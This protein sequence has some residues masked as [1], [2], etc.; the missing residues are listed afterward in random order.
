METLSFRVTGKTRDELLRK[1]KLRAALYFEDDF[2]LTKM[3]TKLLG[4]SY[5]CDFTF[6]P[7][8]RAS[9]AE[10]PGSD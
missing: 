4:S 2:W 3:E 10:T 5:Q 9:A 8:I 6:E 7:A 1:G